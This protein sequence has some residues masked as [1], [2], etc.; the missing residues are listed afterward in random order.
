MKQSLLAIESGCANPGISYL[1]D[2]QRFDEGTTL[3]FS[4]KEGFILNGVVNLT[5]F[6]DGTW[7]HVMPECISRLLLVAVPKKSCYLSNSA[8]K[9]VCE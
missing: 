3:E 1:E 5:C 8:K 7:S 2:G 4:C 9:I 6:E